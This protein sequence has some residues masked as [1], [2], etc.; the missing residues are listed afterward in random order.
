MDE[1]LKLVQEALA[2]IAEGRRALAGVVGQIEDGRLA[3]SAT[4]RAEVDRL[5][6]AEQTETKQAFDG[7]DAAIARRL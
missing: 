2:T 5:L 6:I 7:L 4:T 1:A 3:V